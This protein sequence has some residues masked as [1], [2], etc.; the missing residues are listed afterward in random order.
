MPPQGVVLH[1]WSAWLRASRWLDRVYQRLH[2]VRP[3]R[4][5]DETIGVVITI[6]GVGST[7]VGGADLEGDAVRSQHAR[8]LD[9]EPVGD[10]EK[11]QDAIASDASRRTAGVHSDTA[12]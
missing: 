3:R 8:D 7:D 10:V 1:R 11:R 2:V 4:R 6:V 5:E 12:S 9:G